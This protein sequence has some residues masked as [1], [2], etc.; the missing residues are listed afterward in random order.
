MDLVFPSLP[1]SKNFIQAFDKSKTNTTTIM[2]GRPGRGRNSRMHYVNSREYSIQLQGI[3]FIFT[4][5]LVV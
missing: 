3:G 5:F 4:L 1:E 2:A